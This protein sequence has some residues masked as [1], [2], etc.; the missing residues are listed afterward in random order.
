MSETSPRPS[1]AAIQ[2]AARLLAAGRSAEAADQL[3]KLV[4]EAPTYAA[5]HVL[6]ASALDASGRPADALEVWR[7]AAFLVPQSP[8]VHRERQRLVKASHSA[9]PTPEPETVPVDTWDDKDAAP[10]VVPTVEEEPPTETDSPDLGLAPEPPP[11][12][13]GSSPEA[14]P[15]E[16]DEI[17]QEPVDAPP[18]STPR[19]DEPL[20][21]PLLP[22]EGDAS[23]MPSPSPAEDDLDD[24]GWAILEDDLAPPTAEAPLAI[25]L[26]PPEPESTTPAA[27][28]LE[29]EPKIDLEPEATTPDS[30]I[31]DD[32]DALITQLDAAPRIKPDPTFSGPKVTFDES[33]MD[34][35]VSETL[36]K[37]YAAQHQYVE[38]AVV[39][40]KLAEREP[41]H[42]DAHLERAAEL[43]DKA[44]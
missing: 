36:A 43:R 31:A 12:A 34:D 18:E 14:A 8:L 37:I 20:E 41:D 32:L 11:E 38:A 19:A 9:A 30:S 28:Q 24:D 40:E 29:P 26:L 25:P 22:P 10:D 33:S 4:D 21:M 6:L 5:A 1:E 35:M 42:A 17:P 3:Q 13:D 44:S 15:T 7:R 39:Y 23:A 27:A 2:T 16:P